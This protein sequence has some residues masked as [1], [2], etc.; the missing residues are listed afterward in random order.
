MLRCDAV[1]FAKVERYAIDAVTQSV[2]WRAVRENVP[3]MTLAMV[4]EQFYSL[5]AK[6]QVFFGVDGAIVYDVEEAWPAAAAFKFCGAV[7]KG[8]FAAGTY[9]DAI[10]MVVPK[11]PCERCFCATLSQNSV[12]FS[13]ELLIPIDG[14][15]LRHIDGL[16][17]T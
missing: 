17:A 2:R 13:C 11:L 5:H 15:F 3:Q 7:E 10:F 14:V 12:F 1:A 8:V 4:T 16:L 6:F 9:V